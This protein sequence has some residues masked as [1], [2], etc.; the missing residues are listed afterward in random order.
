MVFDTL[1]MAE[2]IHGHLLPYKDVFI[3]AK[4]TKGARNQSSSK[5]SSHPTYGLVV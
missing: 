3:N 4:L 1:G 2:A 5:K